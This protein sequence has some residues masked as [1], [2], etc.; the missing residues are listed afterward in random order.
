MKEDVRLSGEFVVYLTCNFFE[1]Q[2]VASFT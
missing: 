1:T 2:A